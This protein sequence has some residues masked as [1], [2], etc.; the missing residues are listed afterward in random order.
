MDSIKEDLNFASYQLGLIYREKFNEN[1]LAADRLEFLLQNDPE[2]RLLL[3]AKY[4]L[5]KIYTDLGMTARAQSLKNDILVAY[6][7]SRYA[8]ILSNPESLLRE[9]NNPTII[10]EELYRRY[11]DQ[12]YAEVI[13]ETEELINEFAGD[14]IVPKLELLKAM[15][16]GR[17]HGFERYRESLNY[18]ALNYPQSIEGKKAQEILDKAL[19][20]MASNQFVAD[21]TVSSF[22]LVLPF[23]KTRREEAAKLK[24]KVSAALEDFSYTG[25]VSLDVYNEDKDFVVVHGFTSVAGVETFAERLANEKKYSVD[26]NYFY[27]STPNYRVAQIHKNI[28]TYL[29]SLNTPPQ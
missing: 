20:S 22:K 19:P 5:Y 29:I 27:I 7:D 25:S 2:D 9:E 1:E 11:E 26:K 8:A 23:E 17:L 21:S 12:N 14:E 16:E 24:E 4:N 3:P 18:V 15:A 10:Y 13:A 6:P 28:E